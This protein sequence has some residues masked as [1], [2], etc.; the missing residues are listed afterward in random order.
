[1]DHFD[2]LKEEEVKAFIEEHLNQDVAQLLLRP[3]KK[4]KPQIKVLAD[5]ILSRQKAKGKISSWVENFDLIFPPP[6][7]IEQASSELTSEYKAS[8]IQG[9]HLVDLTGGM[10]IDCLSF[11]RNFKKVTYV[12]QKKDLCQVYEHNIMS[13][14]EKIEIVND[15]AEN[16]LSSF[17]GMATFY[18]DPARRSVIDKKVFRLEDCTPNFLTL[19]ELLKGKSKKILVKLS[20]L[21]DLSFLVNSID[22]ILE[23]HV[24]SIKNDC[25]EVLILIDTKHDPISPKVFAI[26]L[27][28]SQPKFTFYQ[29]EERSAPIH[30]G[31]ASDYLYEPN[32]SILKAGGFKSIAQ[33]YHL[34]KLHPAT[35]LYTSSTPLPSFPGKVFKILDH[36]PK[37]TLKRYIQDGHINVITRNY[38]SDAVSLKRK[39]KLK[40]GGKYYLIGFREKEN[41]P[42]LVI[43]ER[44]A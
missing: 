19:Q 36:R 1:M 26:N 5:Q 30:Y 42:K 44:L 16:F 41:N 35:H 33:K 2:F 29:A 3:P 6:L 17:N 28:T 31:E 39:F 9:D 20:P 18:L 4:W 21:I 37:E 23:I 25:K 15:T 7:S 34:E 38:P 12:E 10:G 24:V 40:D 27:G 11:I 14:R 22:S 8:L 13:L 32:V 43:A